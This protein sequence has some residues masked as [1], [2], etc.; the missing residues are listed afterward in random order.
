MRSIVLIDHDPAYA[1]RL[2]SRLSH[3]L[4]MEVHGLSPG[5]DRPLMGTA[6]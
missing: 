6:G 1:S 3:L 2:A 4:C 5:P